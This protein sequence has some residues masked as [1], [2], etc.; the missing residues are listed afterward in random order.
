MTEDE[1][2]EY[3]RLA[4]RLTELNQ[5]MAGVLPEFSKAGGSQQ[6]AQEDAHLWAERLGPIFDEHHAIATRMRQLVAGA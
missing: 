3:D 6:K 2:K 4:A 5:M 1:R